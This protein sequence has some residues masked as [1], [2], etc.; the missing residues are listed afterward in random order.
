M[1]TKLGRVALGV[2]S[3]AAVLG[4]GA[5]VVMVVVYFGASEYLPE[6]TE[7]GGWA[8]IAGPLA[9]GVYTAGALDASPATRAATAVGLVFAAFFATELISY[10]VSLT[11][12]RGGPRGNL[13]TGTAGAIWLL[14]GA[15]F[16]W[17]LAV[18][19]WPVSGPSRPAARPDHA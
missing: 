16:L 15:F 1:A 12:D 6:L 11:A 4:G 14:A 17:R 10:A 3:V 9:L 2:L 18:R 13:E 8:I 5:L 19:R 7:F